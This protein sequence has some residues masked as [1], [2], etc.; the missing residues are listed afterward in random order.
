MIAAPPASAARPTAPPLLRLA[1]VAASA[2][3]GLRAPGWVW[4]SAAALVVFPLAV[5]TQD[6]PDGFGRPVEIVANTA[7]LLIEGA[8]FLWAAARADLPARLRLALRV[9]AWTSLASAANYVLL[10]P[11]FWGGPVLLADSV[12][13]F[14]ALAS[15]LGSFAALVIYPHAPARPGER[16]SLVIDLVITAGGLGVLSWV[17]VTLPSV[18]SITDAGE[19]RWIVYFGL[20]QLAML[21]GVN[22]VTVRGLVVPSRRAFWWFV[23][24]Q[25]MYIPVV[26]LSQLESAAQIS[27]VWSTMAYHWGVLPTLVAAAAMRSDPV[28]STFQSRG[29]AWIR[30]FNPLPL[31]APLAVGAGLLGLLA[32]GAYHYALPLAATLVTVSLLLA[33]RLLLSA[34]RSAVLARSE[35]ARERRQQ[36]EKL[37]AVGRLAGG[38]AHEFNNLMARVVGNAELGEASLALEAPARENFARV[39][40]A[41]LRAA[42]LT[43]QLLAFSGQQRTH[44]APVDAAPAVRDVVDEAVRA[45]PAGI[46]ANLEVGPGPFVV[47]ADTTQLAAALEQLIENAVEAMPRGGRLDVG[48][49][50]QHLHEPLATRFISVPPGPYVAVSVRDT[51]VGIPAASLAVVC[52]PFYSTKAPHLAAGLGLASVHGIVAAHSG[53][54][55]IESVLGEGTTAV[56]YLPA[57]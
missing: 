3:A 48:V 51:G 19:Q 44:L 13:S 4:L 43:R 8:A 41:A 12:N 23:V 27:T 5:L 26:Q 2:G 37:Q 22:L 17:L 7:R 33:V 10:L 20:A 9:T 52:D 21:A 57:R 30:D 49:A 36:A 29:P 25:A 40:V 39:K 6:R 31:V 14:L 18:A 47:H 46:V 34:H 42:E 24:G 1:Q 55:L 11:P 38:V 16:A 56:L 54:L 53:G 28:T 50:R 32:S 45:L 35:A 15:Y